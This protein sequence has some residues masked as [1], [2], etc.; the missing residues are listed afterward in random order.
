[1]D[2]PENLRIVVAGATTL[3]GKELVEALGASRFA[4]A[5][6]RLLDD[7]IVAGTLAAAAGEAFVVQPVDEE[8]FEGAQLIFFAGRPAFARARGD[9]ALHAGSR[10]I[11]LSC[12]LLGREGAEIRIPSLEEVLRGSEGFEATAA[13][14]N[15]TREWISPGA[16][17]I[18]ACG[19]SAALKQW[20][21]CALSI[22]FLRPVSERGAEGIEELEGQTVK[23]LSFQPIAQTVFGAQVAFNLLD[24]F[25]AASA[26]KLGEGR[27]LIARS[28]ANYLS[29]RGPVP[30]IQLIQAPSFYSYAFS[31]CAE[32][33]AAPDLGAIEI[34][35]EAAGFRFSQEGEAGPSNVTAAGETR[36]VLS[37]IERDANRPNAV[38]IWGAVDN[39][40][41]AAAN[42]VAIADEVIE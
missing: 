3:L 34:E 37:R 9:A 31:A 39:V 7:E 8:S 4:A 14:R 18:V 35:L 38:W 10:V 13:E 17:T 19:I 24:R 21:K 15:A 29:G 5:D 25:G 36:P 30:A 23:L 16:A 6:L 22:L 27:S 1:M 42:A 28:V 11:D 20:P 41:L 2:S 33:E 40:K 26:E 12:G 32:F